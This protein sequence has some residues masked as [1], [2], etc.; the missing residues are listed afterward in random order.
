MWGFGGGEE[1]EAGRFENGFRLLL[2]LIWR[3]RRKMNSV[4]QNDTVLSPSLFFIYLCII[5]IDETVSF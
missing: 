3:E 2:L 4:V 5:D 1:R